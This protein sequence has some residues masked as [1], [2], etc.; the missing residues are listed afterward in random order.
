MKVAS[1][2]QMRRI[3]ERAQLEYGV[4]ADELMACA[5]AAVAA[6]VLRLFSPSRVCVVCGK[7]NN[8]GDGFVIA[9]DLIYR[10]VFVDVVCLSDPADFKGA[11]ANAL[12]QL[13]STG[14]PLVPRER[15]REALAACDCVVDAV[16]GTGVRGAV[17]GDYAEAISDINSSNK[18]VLAVDVPSGIRD[19]APAEE[20]GPA[21]SADVTVTI[22]LP[23]A[24]LL[25]MPGWSYAG[26]IIAESINFPLP[27]LQDETIELNYADRDE[28]RKWLPG[29]PVESN[30]GTYGSVGVVAGSAPFAGAAILAAKAALRSGCGL[31]FIFTT[32][33]LNP[34]Y[35]IA[36]PEAVTSIV[37]SLSSTGLDASSASDV[38]SASR[39][40]TALLV[41]P[42]LGASLQQAELVKA[43]I[44]GFPRPI[45]IDAD[46]LTSLAQS[47]QGLDVLRTHP[48]LVLTPH[49]G[50]MARLLGVTVNAVQQ[51]RTATARDFAMKYSVVLLLKGAST[52]VARPDGQT[53]ICPG[54]TSALAK[55][56]TGDVLG[57][58]IT[59][60]IAQGMEP[61]RAAVLGASVHLE[62]GRICAARL[63]ER[64]VLAGEVADALPLAIRALESGA[65]SLPRTSA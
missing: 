32:A 33:A 29:R 23:K 63:G 16:L 17:S 53:F 38:I 19:L 22:G 27:L 45:V 9:R 14:H 46:A 59:G 39:K 2:L 48:D 13:R 31:A 61:W 35:K 37:S 28:L 56:G 65:T 1:A 49:P 24:C 50:E 62:A 5:G 15:L 8:A 54:G 3:D 60:F 7:G 55:S 47:S 6:Q 26:R 4:S 18:P 30:K 40:L 25:T 51:N 41:G 20:I 10:A 64:G 36:L 34:V 52:L 58:V 43:V 44:S 21:V 12:Q 57:G 11:A 42:G